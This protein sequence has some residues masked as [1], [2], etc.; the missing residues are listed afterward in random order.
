MDIEAK[1][2]TALAQLAV[3]LRR[4]YYHLPYELAPDDLIEAG[5]LVNLDWDERD[6]LW[7]QLD[8]VVT[9]DSPVGGSPVTV[10]AE[11]G[12]VVTLWRSVDGTGWAADWDVDLDAAERNRLLEKLTALAQGVAAKIDGLVADYLATGAELEEDDRIETTHVARE[13]LEGS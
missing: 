9:L 13:W 8:A 12:P 7:A 4:H 11:E 5:L 6:S 3:Q 1:T 2:G 10:Y